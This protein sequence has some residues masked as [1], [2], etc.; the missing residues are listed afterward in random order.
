VHYL[1][2]MKDIETPFSFYLSK[3]NIVKDSTGKLFIGRAAIAA[4]IAIGLFVDFVPSKEY[5]KG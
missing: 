5:Y 3:F 4:A 1:I 2:S